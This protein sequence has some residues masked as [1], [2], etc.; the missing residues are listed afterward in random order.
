MVELF[1]IFKHPIRDKLDERD[2]I[3]RKKKCGFCAILQMSIKPPF[4]S[5]QL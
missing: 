2:F 5:M 1:Y 4:P 3:K